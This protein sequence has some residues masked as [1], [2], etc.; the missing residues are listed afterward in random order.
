[1]IHVFP[2][3]QCANVTL[4]RE[5]APLGVLPHLKRAAT[6]ASQGI[7]G[8]WSRANG[9]QVNTNKFTE[10]LRISSVLLTISSLV[11]S[12]QAGSANDGMKCPSQTASLFVP[13]SEN[14]RPAV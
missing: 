4:C 8:E 1:M 7:Y 3:E 13:F 2:Y 11:K 10:V 12:F 9:F 5:H 14:C 6:V